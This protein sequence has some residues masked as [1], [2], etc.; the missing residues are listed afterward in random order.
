MLLSIY[1]Q[2][3]SI[4]NELVT[5]QFIRVTSR[6]SHS[7]E[8]SRKCA[9]NHTLNIIKIICMLK[10]ILFVYW[11]YYF[12]SYCVPHFFSQP[13]KKEMIQKQ[14]GELKPILSLICWLNS[15]CCRWLKKLQKLSA[16]KCLI[17]M[18]YIVASGTIFIFAL[19]CIENLYRLLAN[20][21]SDLP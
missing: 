20:E 7:I 13:F 14:L 15:F 19:C 21:P 2:C 9:R 3:M 8:R 1:P 10:K 5:W 6:A 11:T 16:F 18:Q 12:S 4:R 17:H